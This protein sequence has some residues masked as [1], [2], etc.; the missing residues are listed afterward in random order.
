[1]TFIKECMYAC[2][3]LVNAEFH[4]KTIHKRAQLR[5]LTNEISSR[6]IDV[7]STDPQSLA[8]EISGVCQSFLTTGNARRYSTLAEATGKVYERATSTEKPERIE[9]GFKRLDSMLKGLPKGSLTFI[10]AR[11]AVGKSAFALAIAEHAAINYGGATM[12]YSLGNDSRRERRA[13]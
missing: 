6:L 7:P 9:T 13:A 3:T 8:A 1:M 10:G 2:P 12:L 11:P 4:A 5:A